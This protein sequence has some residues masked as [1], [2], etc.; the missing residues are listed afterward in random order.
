MLNIEL[1]NI[2]YMP[3]VVVV[4]RYVGYV[5]GKWRYFFFFKMIKTG[6]II[7]NS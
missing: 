7:F 6:N 3:T 4:Y 5:E 1:P 2:L